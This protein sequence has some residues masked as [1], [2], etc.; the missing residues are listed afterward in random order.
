[1]YDFG[2]HFDSYIFKIIK[3]KR[4]DALENVMTTNWLDGMYENQSFLKRNASAQHGFKYAWN[5]GTGAGNPASGNLKFKTDVTPNRL[6]INY[7][8][9]TGASAKDEFMA[10]AVGYRITFQS[11]T[12][13]NRFVIE[14]ASAAVDVPVGSPTSESHVYL[15]YTIVAGSRTGTWANFEQCIVTIDAA[16]NLSLSSLAAV[17]DIAMING[18][19]ELV[20]VGAT[21]TPVSIVNAGVTVAAL[22]ADTTSPAGT[23]KRILASEFTG[24]G[25]VNPVGIL[26][27]AGGSGIWRPVDG[28]QLIMSG[29]SRLS[30][31]LATFTGVSAT[32]TEFNISDLAIPAGFLVAGR[33]LLIEAVIG[34]SAGGAGVGDATMSFGVNNTTTD[35]ICASITL[36]S[37]TANRAARI[38]AEVVCITPGAAS[39]AV[40]TTKYIPPGGQAAAAV[41]DKTTNVSTTTTNYIRFAATPTAAGDTWNLWSFKIWWI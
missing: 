4:S 40:F 19:G 24:T 7:L 34:K 13:T 35:P 18:S 41:L 38:Y 31:P 17:G 26:A 2:C 15:E 14:V 12:S 9:A 5:T 37:N 23:V 32:E 11:L 25:Y 8:D 21:S 28:R 1:M 39:T 6:R 29:D 30:S 22:V 27:I 20:T 3:P 33:G 36:S 16:S 10:C